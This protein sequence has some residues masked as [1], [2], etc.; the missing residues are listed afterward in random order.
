MTLKAGHF[1]GLL[2]WGAAAF[3]LLYLGSLPGDLGHD[4][5]GDSLCGVWG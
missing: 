3:G 4:L 2:V 1:V 5:F